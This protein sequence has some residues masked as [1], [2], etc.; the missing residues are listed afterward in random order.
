[1]EIC[2]REN[3]PLFRT[4]EHRAVSC[5]LYQESP[6]LEGSELDVVLADPTAERVLAGA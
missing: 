6:R 2:R 1:M 4:A 3:P 5:F